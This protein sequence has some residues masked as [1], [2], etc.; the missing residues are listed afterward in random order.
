MAELLRIRGAVLSLLEK[1]REDKYV[2]SRHV[3][4][5]CSCRSLVISRKLKNS[6]E[7]EVDILVPDDTSEEGPL[8]ELLRREGQQP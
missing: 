8:V 4:L 7:A 3:L 5:R 1:A 6:L 2:L